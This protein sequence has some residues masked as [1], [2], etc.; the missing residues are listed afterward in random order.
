MFGLKKLI[1]PVEFVGRG[2]ET[3]PPQGE[4][5]NKTT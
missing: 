5:S 4:N 3:Q 1:H 2:S